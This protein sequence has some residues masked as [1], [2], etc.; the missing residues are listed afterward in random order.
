MS[1][2]AQRPIATSGD[3][4]HAVAYRGPVA[5]RDLSITVIIP[6]RD[7]AHAIGGVVAGTRTQLP[8]ARIV[9][10]AASRT[11]CTR[12]AASACPSGR[13]ITSAAPVI[14]GQKSS[15]TD[16]SKPYGVF[17]STRSAAVRPYCACIHCRRLAIPA[18]V[19]TAPFGCP[20]D[21]DV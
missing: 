13:A 3:A 9:V 15:Q 4:A 14:S 1:H 10:I 12:Y 7:E 2:P 6:A 18:C 20:V 5:D 19:F 21:P 16:T 17:C 11:H 8:A